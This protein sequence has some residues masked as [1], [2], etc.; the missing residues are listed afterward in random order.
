ERLVRAG[1][2]HGQDALALD[3]EEERL[4]A[5][6][7]LVR[8]GARDAGVIRAHSKSL[9]PRSPDDASR[10][11]LLQGIMRLKLSTRQFLVLGLTDLSED[12]LEPRR[13]RVLAWLAVTVVVIA[14]VAAGVFALTRI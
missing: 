6:D 14:L 4:F 11:K 8:A 9:A 1:C 10:R 7:P 12:E 5:D 2:A 13:G 3:L